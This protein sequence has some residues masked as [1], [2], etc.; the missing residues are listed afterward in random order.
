[1]KNIKYILS[2]TIL[3]LFLF[4][5]DVQEASQ[6]T[7]PIGST[8][9]YPTASF[10]FTGGALTTNERNEAVYVYDIVLDKPIRYSATFNFEILGGDATEGEDFD[11]VTGTIPAFTTTGQMMVLIHNDDDPTE[12]TETLELRVVPGPDVADA[13]LINPNTQYPELNLT[14]ENYPFCFWTLETSDTYGDGWN[15]G[16]VEVISEGI[17]TE[18]AEP[19]GGP[20]TFN[21][22]ITADA[23]YSFTYVSGGGTGGGPGWESENYFKLTAPDGTFWEEG[24]MDYSGIPTAG[25]ITSGTND[26]E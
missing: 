1:M 25:L 19:E 18:Y 26:C 11:F 9:G 16:Y 7:A 2:S 23:D 3:T 24:T 17:T 4:G 10:T 13:Y 12:S 20:T 6:D 8:D 5:C 22:A 14:I 15:G 21:I